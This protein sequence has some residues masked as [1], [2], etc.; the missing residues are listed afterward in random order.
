M[1]NEKLK[2]KYSLEEAKMKLESIES[3]TRKG[4]EKFETESGK[5]NCEV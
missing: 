4:K 3:S 1:E 2:I 5:F